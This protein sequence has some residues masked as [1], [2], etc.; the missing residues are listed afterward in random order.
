MMGR[1]LFT[2]WEPS[3]VSERLKE[4]ARYKFVNLVLDRTEVSQYFSE[5]SSI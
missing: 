2:D 1:S 3:R 5:R 4:T